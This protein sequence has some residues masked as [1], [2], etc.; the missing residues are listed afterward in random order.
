MG[1]ETVF[2]DLEGEFDA[3]ETAERAAEID[4]RTRRETALLRLSDVLRASVGSTIAVTVTGPAAVRG[5]IA[6]IGPDWL[7]L[8][9]GAGRQA[10]IPLPGVLSITGLGVSAEDPS[11]RGLVKSRIGLGYALR[12][13]ARD[14][15]AVVVFLVAGPVR[16]GTIDRVGA[17][18]FVLAEHAIDEVRHANAITQVST[19]PFSAVAMIRS[20]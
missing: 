4:D 3:A 11:R 6:A 15:A 20:R 16:S 17:D 1:W 18:H 14:R 12:G 10:L 13:I 5:A 9:E 7:L 2:A 19:L 8:A